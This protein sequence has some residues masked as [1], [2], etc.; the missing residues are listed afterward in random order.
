MTIPRTPDAEPSI[1]GVT[2]PST[3]IDCHGLQSQWKFRFDNGFG[4]LV[5]RGPHTYGG[6]DG[7]FELAVLGQDGHLNYDTPIT[8]DVEGHLTGEQV[9]ELLDRIAALPK[10]GASE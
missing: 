8:N 10:P 5:I 4:A 2:H 6:R 1:D 7:L 9:Q 3:Y